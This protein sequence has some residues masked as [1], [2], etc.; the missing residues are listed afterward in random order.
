MI[1]LGGGSSHFSDGGLVACRG[2][3]YQ[4][5]YGVYST[6]DLPGSGTPILSESAHVS[7]TLHAGYII[8]MILL[9]ADC[10]Q[11][12]TVPKTVSWK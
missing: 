12:K 11:K 5:S 6:C 3:P 4:D 10:F 8:F 2:G 7:L 1:F 9:S